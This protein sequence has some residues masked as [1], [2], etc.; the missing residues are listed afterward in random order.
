MAGVADY[1]GI[2]DT[3]VEFLRKG[4]WTLLFGQLTT[5]QQEIIQFSLTI[6]CKKE[7]AQQVSR[8]SHRSAP[9]KSSSQTSATCSR[10]ELQS[11]LTMILM[12]DR[13]LLLR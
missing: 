11:P 8:S 7:A 3:S 1:L 10:C 9:V 2:V 13:D 4:D 6:R 5:L 12:R